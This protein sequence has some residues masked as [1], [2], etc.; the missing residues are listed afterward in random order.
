MLHDSKV[1]SPITD[2]NKT[3][4]H[5]NFNEYNFHWSIRAQWTE[6]YSEKKWQNKHALFIILYV[7]L[8]I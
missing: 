4:Y 3:L 1:L 5:P 7:E 6:R 2:H 8:R